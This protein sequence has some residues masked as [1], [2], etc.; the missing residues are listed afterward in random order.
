[1]TQSERVS[2]AVSP[3]MKE[4][5]EEVTEQTGLRVSEI[6]R[7]GLLNQIDELEGGSE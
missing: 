1:M 5:L 4:R 6:G 2:F 7:R 3:Q